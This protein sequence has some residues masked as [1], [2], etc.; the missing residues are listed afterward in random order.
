MQKKPEVFKKLEQL[1]ELVPTAFYWVDIDT[2]ILGGNRLAIDMIKELSA[3]NESVIGKTAFDMYQPEIAEEIV[4]NNKKT[5]KAK[6]PLVF[7]ET[8]VDIKTNKTKFRNLIRSPLCNENNKVIAILIL[9]YDIT[10]FKEKTILELEKQLQFKKL[11]DQTAYEFKSPLS[12]LLLL[13][14]Q[15]SGRPKDT[16]FEILSNLTAVTPTLLY[17][18]DENNTLLISNKWDSDAV[19]GN[20]AGKTPYDYFPFEVADALI[21]NNNTV[22]Q[23]GKIL[24]FEETLINSVNGKVNY[25]RAFKAPVY[26][27]NGK[28]VGIIG[29]SVNINAEKNAEHLRLEN[30]FQKVKLKEQEKYEMIVSQ[31]AHDIRSPTASLSM[32]IDTCKNIPEQ[33]R[34]T[35]IHAANRITDIANNLLKN[36]KKSNLESVDSNLEQRPMLASLTLSSIV[37]E[38]RKQYSGASTIIEV[39]YEPSCEFLFINANSLNF[40]RMMSNLI[41]NAFEAINNKKGRID[42]T[43]S[44]EPDNIKISIKDNG[45]GMPQAILDKIMNDIKITEGKEKGHGIGFTQVR[46]TLKNNNGKM[47]IK[48][49]ANKGTK[50]ALSFPI[51][52]PP[53]WIA[54]KI[55]LPKNSTIVVLDDDPSIHSAWELCFKEY[56][57]TT[58]LKHFES[59]QE[60]VEFLNSHPEK[61]S[62]FL[63]ADFE[64]I[65]QEMNGLQVIEKTNMSQRS[66]L[67]TSHYN[68]KQIIEKSVKTGIKI[69]PKQLASSIQIVMETS[70]NRTVDIVIIEDDEI[71][72][73]SL[74]M[75]LNE[76]SITTDIYKSPKSFLNHL[77]EYSKK[78]KICTDNKFAKGS[79]TGIDLV[80]KLHKDGYKNLFL[81]SG[82]EFAENEIPDF[83]NVIMKG[84]MEELK[85]LF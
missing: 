73:K 46:E 10:E 49:A 15:C 47:L 54:K 82:K 55:M 29:T 33:E 30:E 52:D 83:L 68:R 66:F 7:E 22:M 84:N 12:I 1:A 28:N 75:Y 4:Q 6:K 36:Y 72:A 5:A 8:V 74:V 65:D 79:I 51:I 20:F 53:E 44:K 48:S 24:A 23:S 58:T 77:S 26:D 16:I 14:H 39:K 35:L 60:V 63:L 71:F 31:L 45:K 25:F 62:I 41:D 69:L 80:K 32:I 40:E 42:I 64:L 56:K 70:K 18:F 19:G 38:K 81:L 85:Q 37:S 43:L 3:S 57:N 61:D 59:S 27:D 67:V 9:V 11:V 13:I 2:T 34:I 50:I 78:T 17:W 76:R 21:K